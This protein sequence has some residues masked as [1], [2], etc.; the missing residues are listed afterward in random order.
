LQKR[1]IPALFERSVA[2]YTTNTLLLEKKGSSYGAST[3]GEV[4]LQVHRCAAG[5]MTLGIQR[6]DR[7][8]LLS[9]GRND[10]V[11]A[12][13]GILYAGGVDV[14]LSVKIEE[15]DEIRFRL[16]HSGCRYA[17]VSGTQAGKIF[18][19]RGDLPGLERVV[20]FDSDRAEGEGNISFRHLLER[21][22]EFLEANSR[23]F[24]ARVESVEESD[25]ANICYTSGTTADPK[26]IVLTHVNY[27]A[28]VEQTYKVL[29]F[30]P[31]FRTLLV[32]PW[33]H[34]FAHVVIYLLIRRG[35]SFASVQQGRTPAETLRNIPVNIREVRPSFMLSV[36]ALAKNFRKNI[37]K[38]IREKGKW[39][40]WLLDWGLEAAYACN[41]D[42]YTK[43]AA[44]TLRWRYRLADFLLFRKIRRGFGGALEFFIG[45]GALL[46]LE[47]QKFFYAVGMPM[48]QGYGLTEAAPVISANVPQRHKLG[49]S[50][51]VV[52]DLQIR[53]CDD[54][55][56]ELPPG[57]QGEIVVRG[58]NVMAGYWRNEMATAEALREGWLYTGDVGYVDGEG[59]LFVLGRQKSLLI[60]H[61]GEKFSPE[62]I[63]EALVGGSP[64][65]DQVMLYNN[66]SQYTIALVVP[67]LKA[68]A[69]K[70][71][72]DG[73]P[74]ESVA[75]QDAAIDLVEH[76]ISE[77]RR[78][79]KSAG[80]FPERWLPSTFALIEEAFSEQ[81]HLLNS[82]LKLVRSRVVERYRDRLESLYTPEGRSARNP[83]NRAALAAI[84]E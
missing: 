69:E 60:G 83:R 3:Y 6:G 79:G 14:P 56:R 80:T 75:G 63:E 38:G 81:N 41:G 8:A 57:E 18:R 17:I 70:L 31:S 52:P 67:N 58:E 43:G 49:S 32:L 64:F 4:Q 48:Y 37:E 28:N 10:W 47:L 84:R 13:L 59:F 23:E 51:S 24:V 35:A 68:I 62:G 29:Q 40:E 2:T 82:T 11:I 61:D 1:T 36:P 45:G 76:E 25:P 65:I 7:V 27:V 15:L 12:E 21:G 20:L 33:D 42:G 66:Q 71:A 77:Y 16:A 72:G 46:D 22:A 50:G 5:L 74:L 39:L 53:I 34:S 54:Q 55:G 30:P 26:G 44:S 19:V 9:E 78:G 73:L